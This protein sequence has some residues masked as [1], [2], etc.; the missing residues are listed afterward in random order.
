MAN[1]NQREVAMTDTKKESLT[2]VVDDFSYSAWCMKMQS[3]NWTYGRPTAR[4]KKIARLLKE[5]AASLETAM[6][7]MD[8]EMKEG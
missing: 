2:R 7:L 1:I 8:T 4:Q 3:E 5:A 6:E